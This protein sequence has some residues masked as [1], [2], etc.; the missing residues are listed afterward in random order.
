MAG[1]LPGLTLSFAQLGGIT[2]VPPEFIAAMEL[3]ETVT[4]APN[5]IGPDPLS[6]TVF[7]SRCETTE[8][9]ERQKHTYFKKPG[10]ITLMGADSNSEG[11]PVQLVR[12]LYPTTNDVPTTF[13]SAT[14][15]VA[16]QDLGNGWSIQSATVSGTY[17]DGVFVPSVF[18]AD[19][20]VY[21]IADVVP[22]KFKAT[23]PILTHDDDVAGTAAMPVP[24]PGD[25]NLS[26]EQLDPYTKKVHRQYRDITTLPQVL[27]DLDT[28]D[29]KQAVVVRETLQLATAA[30]ATPTDVN[31]VTVQQLG[32]GLV[33]QTERIAP[34]VF[35]AVAI[36]QTAPD[37]VPERF[38]AFLPTVTSETTLDGTASQPA[39]ATGELAH[40]E[41]QLDVFLKRVRSVTRG[42][43]PLPVVLFSATTNQ[44]KQ[45]VTITETLKGDNNT[46][47]LPS[48]TKDVD[49]QALGNGL[50][51]QTERDVPTVFAGAEYTQ[52]RVD[53]LPLK[54]RGVV[55]TNT[56]E[57]TTSGT[58]APPTLPTGGLRIT[59]TQID[60]FR[61][62]AQS[63]G[64]DLSVLP[65]TLTSK[66]TNEKRQDV[67]L[68]ETM[69]L[70]TASIPTQTALQ[71]VNAENLGNG[72][73]FVTVQSVI[74]YALLNGTQLDRRL[75]ITVPYQEQIED[76]MT[77][78]GHLTDAYT[79]VNPVTELTSNVRLY[80][81]S[82]SLYVGYS[83]SFPTTVEV[84]FEDELTSLQVVVLNGGGAGSYSESPIS[85]TGGAQLSCQGS[86]DASAAVTAHLIYNIKRRGV[87]EVTAMQYEFMLPSPVTMTQVLSRATTLAGTA[88]SP[89]PIFKP[90]AINVVLK[91][92]KFDSTAKAAA[93]SSIGGDGS[94]AL[95]KG[96]GTSSQ[97]S[98]TLTQNDLPATL[99]GAF[100]LSVGTVTTAYTASATSTIG[101]A[102][103][104][105]SVAAS[106]NAAVSPT[107]I[108]ATIPP[109]IPTTGLF[110]Y[111]I[112]A[113]NY[114]DGQVMFV[115]VV[116][117]ASTF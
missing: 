105:A 30:Q 57:L 85:Y 101:S 91:S 25:L 94:S 100:S 24:Q 60:A 90:E 40:V 10:N 20:Y 65:I 50:Y 56:T 110:A 109:S 4:P 52:E 62:R 11:E 27:L 113:Q 19:K 86:A 2:G 44:Q 89:W 67:T 104:N 35:S 80:S 38:R 88:V 41:T 102:N 63:M 36:T 114:Q 117:D 96:Q 107:T 99:H 42:T 3:K 5:N 74:G 12:T 9:A 16:I 59:Q 93:R 31:Q 48:A 76:T 39:L 95:T 21:E 58:A 79:E 73:T 112:R 37:L 61:V 111:T 49:I 97:Y 84:R 13:P 83:R 47:A 53:S 66:T 69:Q 7:F 68:T 32:A 81:P 1:K 28:N 23:V 17:V 22:E 15:K 115:L 106:A 78:N 103:A 26:E 43:L 70:S 87:R 98:P 46:P 75:G 77:A 45:Y 34:S 18:P 6:D 108:P 14:T 71:I 54:Y 82:S 72:T 92:E 8:T 116:I 64:R 55:P 29:Y 51:F 33:L